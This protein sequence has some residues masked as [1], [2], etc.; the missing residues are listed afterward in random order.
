MSLHGDEQVYL[1]LDCWRRVFSLR[2]LGGGVRRYFLIF[3]ERRLIEL[4]TSHVANVLPS[5]SSLA[6]YMGSTYN[7][8]YR[9]SSG[10]Q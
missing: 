2:T 4:E 3:S 9:T 1:V 5:E 7:D 6:R 10:E 8:P